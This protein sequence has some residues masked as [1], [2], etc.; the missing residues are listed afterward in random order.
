VALHAVRSASP[1]GRPYERHRPEETVLYRTIAAHWSELQGRAGEAV[2]LPR[3]VAREVEEYL[4]CGLL[5]YGLLGYDKRLCAEVLEALVAL[6]SRSYKRRAKA[7]LG[8]GSTGDAMTRAVSVMHSAS[9]RGP[10]W[11]SS[12]PDQRGDSALRLNVHFYLLALD[13]VYVRSPDSGELVFHALAAP[14]AEEMTDVA[15][16]TAQRV[17]KILARHGRTIGGIGDSDAEEPHGEQ[18]ALAALCGAAA[19]GHGL[20]GDRAGEPLLRVVDPARARKTERVGESSG[21]NEHAE[22]DVPAE[23]RGRGCCTTSSRSTSRPAHGAAA[24]PAG[25]RPRP[26]PTPP[27]GCSRSMSSAR[28]H[29]LGGRWET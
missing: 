11:T 22:V 19:A 4:R 15:A 14:S 13:G 17:Q 27:P 18:L 5:E 25:S 24:P 16:R 9:L 2:E 12:T 20:T 6:V 1:A 26:R 8:L 28:G 23:S 21:L 7:L 10:P 29:H 3:F